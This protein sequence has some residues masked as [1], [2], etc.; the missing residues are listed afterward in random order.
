MLHL[1]CNHTSPLL[2][3]SLLPST[4]TYSFFVCATELVSRCCRG[5]IEV[6]LGSIAR[7]YNTRQHKTRQDNTVQRNT[8]QH[9]TRQHKIQDEAKQDKTRREP[10]LGKSS[11]FRIDGA[12]FTRAIRIFDDAHEAGV[13]DLVDGSMPNVPSMFCISKCTFFHRIFGAQQG[14]VSPA[15][16]VPCVLV[17]LVLRLSCHVFVGDVTSNGATRANPFEP[18]DLASLDDLEVQSRKC[19]HASEHVEER[20]GRGRGWRDFRLKR[21]AKRVSHQ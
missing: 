3:L 10:T 6:L 5:I 15:G 2:S 21:E 8:R 16:I 18:K 11:C 12:F 13:I 4:R 9:K 17:F 19:M 20:R 14:L 1:F 7:K